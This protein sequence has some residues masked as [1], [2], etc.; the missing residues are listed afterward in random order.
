MNTPLEK[1]RY[2]S[3]ARAMRLAL[4]A[5]SSADGLYPRSPVVTSR[6]P[7][8]PVQSVSVRR[9][10][11]EGSLPGPSRTITVEPIRVPAAPP[12]VPEVA[13]EL[14]PERPEPRPEREPVP[15]R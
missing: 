11:I 2:A 6:R 12:V 4:I 13:P 1:M 15:V 5:D 8:L 3:Q 9:H 14:P 7:S 10:A